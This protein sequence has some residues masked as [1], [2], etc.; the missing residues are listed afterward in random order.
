MTRH[1]VMYR[2]SLL[3]DGE[4]A[5][6]KEN[7]EHTTQTRM[8]IREGDLVIGRC[9]MV[10]FY[11][12][13][14]RDIELAGGRC[15]NS[16]KQHMYVADLNNYVEDL[17]EFTPRTWDDLSRIPRDI[18]PLVLKGETNSKKHAWATHMFAPDWQSAGDVYARLTQ[19]G[20]IGDQKIY[21]REY[22][23]LV[24][25]GE[26]IGGCPISKEFRIFV[27]DEEPIAAGF[28]WHAFEDDVIAQGNSIPDTT[29]IPERFVEDV[30][31]RV[32]RKVPFYV[33]DV[34]QGVDGRWWVIELNDGQQSGLSAND[35]RKL[36]ANLKY[37]LENE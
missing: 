3:D 12:E 26:S 6:I 17:K 9:C 5:A 16:Y 8:D 31:I 35:P 24:K 33:I 30:L 10:P 37:C 11:K 21:I 27:Y 7:F 32:G 2:E 1:V 22:V 14:A 15:I 25:L 18:G 28:Y 13:V 23:P 36:Y 34:A 4:L 29:E 20:L 19:D